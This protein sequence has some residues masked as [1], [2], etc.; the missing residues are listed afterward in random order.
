MNNEDKDYNFYIEDMFK[1]IR[2]VSH[3][4]ID[5]KKVMVE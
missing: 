4:F 2:F 1:E 3:L 5:L